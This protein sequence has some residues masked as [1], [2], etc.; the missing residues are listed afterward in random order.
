VREIFQARKVQV[1]AH[2]EEFTETFHLL[3][4]ADSI[5]TTPT[6][7]PLE[8][9]ENQTG[10]LYGNPLCKPEMLIV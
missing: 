1:K 3:A 6:L 8:V 4:V 9:I 2:W 5:T 10:H 7:P